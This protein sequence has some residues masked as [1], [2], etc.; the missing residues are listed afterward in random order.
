MGLGFLILFSLLVLLRLLLPE[1]LLPPEELLL[2]LLGLQNDTLPPDVELE[3]NDCDVIGGTDCFVNTKLRPGR[4]TLCPCA[5]FSRRGVM[6]GGAGMSE[7][8]SAVSPSPS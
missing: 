2:T 4:D 3:V 1:L 5:I 7:P 8:P 6:S